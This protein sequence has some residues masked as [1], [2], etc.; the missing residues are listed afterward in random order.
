MTTT[1]SRTKHAHTMKQLLWTLLFLT[2]AYSS[3]AS[4]RLICVTRTN[5]IAINPDNL[6]DI[7]NIGPISL[8]EGVEPGPMTFDRRTGRLFGLGYLQDGQD[9]TLYTDY[10]L[11]Y[12]LQT[13]RATI[14][15]TLGVAPPDRDFFEGI[16]YIDSARGLVVSHGPVGPFSTDLARVQTNCSLTPLVTTT[17]D[18]DV[19][20]YDP[21]RH[22]FYSAD[23][24]F[25]LSRVSLSDGS[26][27]LLGV[28]PQT[29][30]D[31]A[32]STADDAIYAIDNYSSAVYRIT[33][34]AGGPPIAVTTI[35]QIPAARGYGLA[36]VPDLPRISI[37][38]SEVEVCWD[39]IPDSAYRVDY[40]SDLTT[41]VWVTLREC[42]ASDGT[43]T[44]ILDK[45]MRGE[46]QRFYRTVVTNC[47]VMP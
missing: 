10:I 25:S 17:L 27:E 7:V 40:R 37:R 12:S 26:S 33:T 2:T 24:G 28:P 11:E 5:L 22:M 31:L 23:S 16:E 9:P 36:F 30:G 34:T 6:A 42:I 29:M 20:A 1:T 19:M 44:C 15:C 13:G 14:L 47:V 21:I 39:S 18:N 41:N 3:L 4:G 35:G 46:P 8:P 38:V 45:V 43:N 32:F